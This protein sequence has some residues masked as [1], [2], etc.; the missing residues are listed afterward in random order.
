ML[1][2]FRPLLGVLLAVALHWTAPA[3]AG[4]GPDRVVPPR[5]ARLTLPGVV[6]VKL[7]E[8][9]QLARPAKAT[10]VSR[11]DAILRQQRVADVG[12]VAPHLRAPSKPGGT[13]LRGIWVVHYVSGA[14]PRRV[15]EQLAALP[16]VEYA[17]PQ[18]CYPLDAVPN[19]TFWAQQSP[20]M[21]RMHLP[22]A[23]NLTKGEQGGVVVG[24]VDGGTDWQ[25][26]DL[27]ANIWTNPGE[28]AG[29]HIDDDGNGYIDDVHGW[30]FAN[31]TND[32]RGVP[33]APQSYGHG[34]HTAGI[35]CA[36]SNNAAGIAGASWNAKLMPICAA[37]PTKDLVIAFGYEG[38]LYA[39]DNGADIINCSW[40]GSGATSDFE[41][42]VIDHAWEH[43]TAI[44]A[45]AGNCSSGS[46]L[47]A[48]PHYPSAYPH[49]L[50]V[51][52]VDRF[53]IKAS[54]S[55]YGITV[56]CSAQG[57][58][59]LSTIPGNQYDFMTGT[60]MSSPQ[61]AG[62][63]A[64]V[65]TRWPGYT[66]DQVM[67]RVR[68][69][70]DN[71]DGSN[72]PI[73][74]GQIGYGRVNALSALTKNTPAVRITD[75]HIT[76]ANGN[77]TL[78]PDE[79]VSLDLKVTNF[80]ARAT[81][82]NF[83]LSDTSSFAEVQNG[84]AALA[85]LDSMQ[86]VSL[87][88][89]TVHI[90]PGAPIQSEVVCTLDI[91]TGS[92]AYADKDHVT[93]IVLPQFVTHDANHVT[94]SVT[95]VGKLGFLSVGGNGSN[96]VGFNYRTRDNL[97][98]EGALLIG[99]DVN[100][101][102]NAARGLDGET[103]DDDF[104]TRP[105]GVPVLQKP[106]PKADQ[107]SVARFT[108]SL[109]TSP[110]GLVVRQDSYEFA[111]SID[112]DYVILEYT[113]HNATAA[114]ITGLRVA[115]FCDWDVD[116]VT[117]GTNEAGADLSRSL[118]YVH[119]TS[120]GGPTTYAG[121]RVLTP[122][123]MTN[124]HAIWNDEDDPG[125]PSW[126]I[127]QAFDNIEKWECLSSSSASTTSGPGDVSNVVATGPFTIAAGDSV[128]VAFAV[129]AGDNLHF[130]QVNA[131]AAW[132]KWEFL[133]TGTPIELFDLSATQERDD[134]MVRWRT[135]REERV[136]GYRVFRS[137]DSGPLEALHPDE[138][139]TSSGVYAFR[140]AGVAPGSYVYRVGE[141]SPEGAIALHGQVG[142]DVG[143]AAPR[144]SFLDPALPNPFN[145][146]TSLSF[147][148]AE[149]GRGE[150]A[151]F[152]SRGRLVRTLWRVERAEPGFYHQTWDGRDDRGARVA[153]GVYHA[154]LQVAGRALV[155][156]LTLLK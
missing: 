94:T 47:C 35:V 67:E 83:L 103:Q 127:Y 26:V 126:G 13:D 97:L 99:T 11:V 119:D 96:G 112:A 80:L 65:K 100:H 61:A 16:E 25:H 93:L 90:L 121:I 40:G 1:A 115:Y 108:D 6:I 118:G 43:G 135:S 123:E 88:T 8:P 41:R 109:A 5:D 2:R 124:Y 10:G 91:T 62:V 101:I 140:D 78:E 36:T 155:Q 154:R 145:P 77:G 53:D 151:I 150:L 92:P 58:S 73:Y 84:S 9:A 72:L 23:W 111:D 125:N 102:S 14:D 54:S 37:H 20:Y 149:A 141:V 52:N 19:D 89:M 50:S 51:A 120:T 128:V 113:I 42:A 24:D 30:N 32:P 110:L 146:S 68:V 114:P 153:S 74:A 122:P 28:I 46:A 22:E 81:T 21:A 17:E 31:Y 76:D 139:P 75:V 38:I 144:R 45:A 143:R 133:R 48:E 106:G 105:G 131:D 55:N 132:R 71:I 12:P 95:S 79:I 87:P 44:V 18:F 70:S 63:C 57:I 156:R 33:G 137:R 129:V 60:S 148:V 4:L 27:S 104:A 130:L 59:I 49:V 117:A 86:T 142:I 138:S 152:D 64:L 85:S 39:T 98:F 107:Q 136:A 7:R 69:T 116:G 29:N 56:D 147:G 134:V 34:T 3:R 82:V 66:P 15:A